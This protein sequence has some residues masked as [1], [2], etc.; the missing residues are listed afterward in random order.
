MDEVTPIGRV[1][2]SL[3]K[4]MEAMSNRRDVEYWRVHFEFSS[5][6]DTFNSP[7][8][9]RYRESFSKLAMKGENRGILGPEVL[10]NFEEAMNYLGKINQG[11]LSNRKITYNDL[12]SL[13]TLMSGLEAQQEVIDDAFVNKSG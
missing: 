8:F 10:G 7:E 5:L 9:K 13:Y 6:N 12:R 2:E 4:L 3:V 11:I 1:K